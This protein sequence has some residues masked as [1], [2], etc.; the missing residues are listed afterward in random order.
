MTAKTHKHCKGCK[1]TLRVNKFHKCSNNNS[2]YQA[3]CISCHAKYKP[4]NEELKQGWN[5][6]LANKYQSVAFT[7]IR[8]L[9]EA[10]L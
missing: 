7:Q 4:E 2:G 5:S 10:A 6:K 3:R 9:S 8:T 1:K